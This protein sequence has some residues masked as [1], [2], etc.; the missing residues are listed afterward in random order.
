M[1]KGISRARPLLFPAISIAI[2]VIGSIAVS[3]LENRIQKSE[4]DSAASNRVL[5]IVRDLELNV[6]LLR[7][8]RGFAQAS[9]SVNWRTLNRFVISFAQPTKEVARFYW[10]APAVNPRAAQP[11]EAYSEDP[12][13][14]YARVD[15]M[16]P[17]LKR[18]AATNLPAAKLVGKQIPV[19]LVGIP[20]E[21]TPGDWSGEG[22][23]LT[24]RV[25]EL[26]E[27]ALS[28]TEQSRV[29]FAVYGSDGEILFSRLSQGSRWYAL[30]TGPFQPSVEEWRRE[31]PIEV[32]GQHWRAVAKPGPG[33]FPPGEILIRFARFVVGVAFAL[34]LAKV[35]GATER[36]LRRSE[37]RFRK[38]YADAAVGMVICDETGRILVVNRAICQ[39]SGFTES[40]LI[41]NSILDI[42]PPEERAESSRRLA[43]LVSG[44]IPSYQVEQRIVRKD[45]SGRWLRFSVS[46]SEGKGSVASITALCEDISE[47]ISSRETLF[48][49]ANHDQLTGLPNRRA[50]ERNVAAAI[51]RAHS[52]GQ[53]MALAY[54]DIDG[55]KVINDSLGHAT[56]DQLLVQ[57]AARLSSCVPPSALLARVGGD[58]FTVVIED[59]H[60]PSGIAA[61][62]DHII[63]AL[64]HPFDN[65]GQELFIS[66]SA[67]ISFYPLDGADADTLLQHADSAMYQAKRDGKGRCCLFTQEMR[68]AANAR[69]EL[70][71]SLRRAV[72]RREIEVHFQPVFDRRTNVV[73]RFEALCR[74]NHPTNG[75]ISP[76]RFIPVAEETGLIVPLGEQVLSMACR[77]AKLW[78]LARPDQPVRVAVNIS[79]VQFARPDFV[80]K[81]SRA[82]KENRLEPGLLELELTESVSVGDLETAILRMHRLRSLGV[83]IAMD[84]FGTG[85]SSLNYL[86]RLP[87]DTLKIDR[88]FIQD[89][90]RTST[91][92]NLVGSVISLAHGLG[93][94]VVGEGVETI[95]QVDMLSNL[96]CDEFQGF[97]L[98]RP[99]R[100]EQA[101]AL[102]IADNPSNLD[103]NSVEVANCV[104]ML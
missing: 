33:Y 37:E 20:V 3:R 101:M 24:F 40:E 55:F 66:A 91:S 93:L 43:N 5:A 27:D 28:R 95:G 75:F 23:F 51:L 59:A 102:V 90:D 97:L 74:W 69:L 103:R 71:S 30:V 39:L 54:I 62:V 70:E 7:A 61:T 17:L 10:L 35:F 13:S 77:Q 79:S 85:Y 94:K 26:I 41:G 38:A 52:L 50:F 47:Q 78:N 21:R 36:S 76:A 29:D 48:H 34:L 68:D 53:S 56:G 67:G 64:Q 92:K 22:V 73:V 80:S 99:V 82:L 19:C 16:A 100:P 83:S 15:E 8:V 12:E 86:Q 31:W 65:N 14:I 25:N 63:R 32:A 89:L 57:V 1:F 104:Q 72:E 18:A 6:D 49:Q 11:L 45:G 87:I 44:C 4:F 84:D 88:T 96:G 46:Q 60:Q 58:E 2:S 81:I 42:I 9:P 98:G